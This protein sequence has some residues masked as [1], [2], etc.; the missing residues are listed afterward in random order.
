MQDIQNNH[1]FSR[2][3]S[4]W[5]LA[6]YLTSQSDPPMGWQQTNEKEQYHREIIYGKELKE[7]K[8]TTSG[9]GSVKTRRGSISPV[10]PLPKSIA[11]FKHMF[12][13][14][15]SIPSDCPSSFP[16]PRPLS[17]PGVTVATR[18]ATWGLHLSANCCVGSLYGSKGKQCAG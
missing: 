5:P 15:I 13:L 2:N 1:E 8:V 7:V 6:S 16:A 11:P 17:F 18:G 4:F 3:Q 12:Y 10:R 9:V 14:S